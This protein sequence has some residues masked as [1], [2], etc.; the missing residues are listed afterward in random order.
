VPDPHALRYAAFDLDGTLLSRDGAF[1]PR[2][3]AAFARLRS[4]GLRPLLI[5][6]RSLAT[7]RTVR[8][9]ARVLDALSDDLLL[10]DG[11]VW[12]DRARDT[13]EVIRELPWDVLEALAGHGVP[14]LVAEID[15]ALVAG[16]RKA[17]TAFAMAYRVPRS[18]IVVD[19]GALRAPPGRRRPPTAVLDSVTVFGRDVRTLPPGALPP[20]E[21][22]VLRALDGQVL[23]PRDSCKAT[24][25]ER[26]LLEREGLTLRSAVTFGDAY[27]DGCLLASSALGVAVHHAD[28]VAVRFSDVLLDRPLD[29]FLMSF[30]PSLAAPPPDRQDQEARA[31]CFGGH[32]CP[33]SESS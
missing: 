7:Y 23:R 32:A 11:N 21:L 28:S 16:S 19:P 25:L 18:S 22:H 33:R 4:L 6:G 17:A 13:C 8:D 24:A 5:T 31:T 30:D 26:Y 3:P 20:H 2:L 10:N 9:T 12:F 29:E 1:L 15:R 14:D 27:N